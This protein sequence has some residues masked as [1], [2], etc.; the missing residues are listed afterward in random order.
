[1]RPVAQE[2]Q[3]DG[4]AQLDR[5]VGVAAPVDPGVDAVA[6]T[7]I[8][9]QLV[10]FTVDAERP[11]AGPGVRYE[12]R[13]VA[14]WHQR[15]LQYVIAVKKELQNGDARARDGAMPGRVGRMRRRP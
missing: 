2:A 5:R 12:R 6:E 15:V 13:S 4:L 11:R 1:M 10:Q 3:R 14:R 8:A 7:D 9:G